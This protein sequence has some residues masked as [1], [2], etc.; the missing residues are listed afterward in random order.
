M[1]GCEILE[2]MFNK[3]D[4]PEDRPY[5]N[6]SYYVGDE[7]VQ[8]LEIEPGETREFETHCDRLVDFSVNA[9]GGTKI[10]LIKDVGGEV[11]TCEMLDKDGNMRRGFQEWPAED[12]IYTVKAYA[13]D[14]VSEYGPFDVTVLARDEVVSGSVVLGTQGGSDG[15]CANCFLQ[16]RGWGG[17]WVKPNYATFQA[18]YYPSI[19]DLAGV[20]DGSDMKVISPHMIPD[21]EITF[22]ELQ[23]DC[24]YTTTTFAEYTGSL[25]PEMEHLTLDEINALPDPP[26]DAYSITLSDGL[27]FVYRTAAGKKG[28]VSV[29]EVVTNDQG[30]YANITYSVYR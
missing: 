6:V 24:G 1:A 3:E 25:D 10:E 4:D 29:A 26:S 14:G 15:S 7:L 18:Q 12:T 9:V 5:I 8:M 17:G 23:Y 16:T 13:E 20:I 19:L 22:V 27:R 28:L 11:S 21:T 2:D 30:T